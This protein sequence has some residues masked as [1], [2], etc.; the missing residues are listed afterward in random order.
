[1]SSPGA[2]ARKDVLEQSPVQR[3]ISNKTK[4]GRTLSR[5]NEKII[6]ILGDKRTKR[7]V[8]AGAQGGLTVPSALISIG[9]EGMKGHVP[10]SITSNPNLSPRGQT[11]EERNS[12]GGPTGIYA[13]MIPDRRKGMLVILSGSSD[14]DASQAGDGAA[15]T[16]SPLHHKT[17]RPYTTRRDRDQLGGETV[18][19][20]FYLRGRGCAGFLPSRARGTGHGG[21][22]I[23]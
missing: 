14:Q 18:P 19:G 22:V 15:K 9:Q 12:C 4:I 7:T 8:G 13:V 3:K 16:S 17:K 5:G 2:S 23:T 20:P 11:L 21:T 6:T 1:V 10:S